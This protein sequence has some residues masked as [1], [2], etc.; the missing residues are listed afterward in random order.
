MLATVR[1]FVGA[2]L[3]RSAGDEP[4]E[5]LKLVV[6]EACSV[7]RPGGVAITIEVDEGRAHVTCEGVEPPGDDEAGTMRAQVIEAL[8][9]D[10]AWTEGVARF[11]LSLT[12]DAP[13]A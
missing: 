6:G 4:I 8:V 2:F 11:S 7:M 3:A 13:P 12:V 1:V 9:P 10:V 5:D